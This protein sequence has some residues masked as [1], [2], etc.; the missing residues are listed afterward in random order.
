EVLVVDEALA[1]GDAI[2]A[3]RCIQ[4]FEEL[5]RRKVTVLF[6]SHDLGLVK[7][8]ADHAIFLVNGRVEAEGSP[9]DVVNRYVGLVLERQR[10]EAAEEQPTGALESSFRHGDAAS[11]ITSVA[12]LNGEGQPVQTVLTGERVAVRVR[13]EFAREVQDLVVGML[14][15]N[16]LGVDV[17]GTNTRLEGKPLGRFRAGERVEV[18]FAFECLLG[19]HEYTLTAATQ[20]WDGSSQDWLDDVLSF[21]VMDPRG[22]TGA[23][24]LPTEV[25]WRRV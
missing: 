17:F 22:G 7:R 13:A 14:V 3:S 15:R 11:R 5:K 4:K 9:N 20:H 1:V 19:Q 24:S 8:L 10:R 23:A 2:F 25:R 6:V 12:M 21:R 18:E 16:R